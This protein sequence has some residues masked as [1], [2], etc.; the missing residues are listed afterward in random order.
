MKWVLD[1]VDGFPKNQ[2]FVLG[3]RLADAVLEVMEVLAG[4]T[5]ARGAA[6]AQL[7]A[8]ANRRI[9][10][11]RWLVRVCKDRNLLSAAQFPSGFRRHSPFVIRHSSLPRPTASAHEK[12]EVPIRQAQGGLR[13]RSRPPSPAGNSAQDD[14]VVF[15]LRTAAPPPRPL[16]LCVSALKK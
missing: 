14:G 13:L 11:V 15:L 8:K 10:A 6:K 9:E 12:L 2:R 4:A 16:R 7:L 1:R 3:T 5:Y